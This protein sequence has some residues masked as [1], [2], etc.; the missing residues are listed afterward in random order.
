LLV[1]CS[2]EQVLVVRRS[3]GLGPRWTA[4]H[5]VSSGGGIDPF[6][7]LTELDCSRSRYVSLVRDT[8]LNEAAGAADATRRHAQTPSIFGVDGCT[9]AAFMSENRRLKSQ[10][11]PQGLTP[12][13]RA[14]FGLSL[15]LSP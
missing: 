1:E 9:I 2:T 12:V 4:V 3:M 14:S 5:F 15:V 8:D 11:F 6:T 13:I 10:T 7:R